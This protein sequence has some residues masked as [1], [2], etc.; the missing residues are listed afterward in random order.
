MKI[1]FQTLLIPILLF[2]FTNNSQIFAQNNNDTVSTQVFS[3]DDLSEFGEDEESKESEAIEEEE[4]EEEIIEKVVEEEVEEE[5][6]IIAIKPKRNKK[7]K[8]SFLNSLYLPAP[9][10]LM[11]E[12]LPVL[13]N[14]KHSQLLMETGKW[15]A[16]FSVA[17]FIVSVSSNFSIDYHK[18]AFVGTGATIGA[19]AGITKGFELGTQYNKL[20]SADSTFRLKKM[21]IGLEFGIGGSPYNRQ[22]GFM[23]I[24][25]LDNFI[26]LNYR[27]FSTDIKIPDVIK[28]GIRRN[29]YETGMPPFLAYKFELG[30]MYEKQ[31]LCLLSVFG[32]PTIGYI[33]GKA[34]ERQLHDY[35]EK[36]LSGS[37]FSA[38]LLAIHAGGIFN[39]YDIL[40][41]SLSCAYDI[42]GVSSAIS[43]YDN[44]D[45]KENFTVNFAAGSYFF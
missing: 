35:Y 10:G 34:D 3:L 8:K 25:G 14:Y 29:R 18:L 9:K 21:R 36:K 12:K 2:L 15:G 16:I 30:A 22:V 43:K 20:K 19:L 23:G 45:S 32:G 11:Y 27:T 42:Q 37:T 41:L 38:P 40:Y 28:L 5:Q 33:Y 6:A 44:Y 39:L 13:D 17:S 31:I 7:K 1:S 26:A 4:E 24:L